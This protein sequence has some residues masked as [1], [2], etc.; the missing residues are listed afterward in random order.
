MTTKQKKYACCHDHADSTSLPKHYK[1]IKEIKPITSLELGNLLP[2]DPNKIGNVT[3]YIDEYCKCFG[4]N[5]FIKSILLD[6]FEGERLCVSTCN[7][8]RY[9]TNSICKYWNLGTIIKL[10]DDCK[11]SD[12]FEELN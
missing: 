11:E 12:Y 5:T 2:D 4:K 6:G 3:V 1:L 7:Y 8:W 9:E 10:P